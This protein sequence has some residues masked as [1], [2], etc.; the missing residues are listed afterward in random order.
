MKIVLDTNVL[1]QIIS[2]RSPHHWLW[3]AIRQGKITLCVTTDILDEYHEMITSFYGNA[4]F[5]DDVLDAILYLENLVRV[6]KYYFWGL[7]IKDE[8]DQKFVDCYVACGA[9]YLIT[10]DKVFFKELPK[11]FF[12]NIKPIKPSDF[13]AIFESSK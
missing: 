2:S 11:V 5:A 6:E 3:N 10:E 9:E 4:L 7:P 12:P 8:D 1:L 13:V